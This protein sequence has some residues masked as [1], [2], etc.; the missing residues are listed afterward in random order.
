MR[1]QA[2][3]LEILKHQ[4]SLVS[5]K[6]FA[7]SHHICIFGRGKQKNNITQNMSNSLSLTA[8]FGD[9]AVHQI[10]DQNSRLERAP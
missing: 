5:P 9:C 8:A 7:Q 4:P 6:P 10:E 1:I 2:T 3:T